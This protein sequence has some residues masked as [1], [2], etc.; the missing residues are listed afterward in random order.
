MKTIAILSDSYA[1]FEGWIPQGQESFYP[2]PDLDV[3]KVE[4]TWWYQ[5]CEKKHLKLI[6]NDSWSR[7]TMSTSVRPKM[8]K[9]CSFV[10]RVQTTFGKESEI[11]PDLILILGATNDAWMGITAGNVQYE[12]WQEE[13]LQQVLP[14][15]CYILHIVKKYQPQAR[16][17]NVINAKRM[18][19]DEAIRAGM[20]EACEHYGIQWIELEDFWSSGGHPTVRGMREIAEQIEKRIEL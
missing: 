2:H 16:I 20:K 13:D 3:K 19:P 12:N 8:D 6:R 4:E 7:A 17:I 10:S 11:K 5:L 9:S 14:A 1:T 18:I 15:F